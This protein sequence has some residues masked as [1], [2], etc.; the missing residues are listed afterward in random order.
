MKQEASNADQKIPS[1]GDD[2]NGIV[3]MFAAAYKT[4]IGKVDEE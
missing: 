1:E 3:A 4:N 2:K